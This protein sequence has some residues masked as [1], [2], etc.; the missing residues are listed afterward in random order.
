MVFQQRTVNTSV[1]KIRNRNR[2]G[3]CQQTNAAVGRI[4]QRLRIFCIGNLIHCNTAWPHGPHDHR[5]AHSLGAAGQHIHPVSPGK[6]F[7]KQFPP[8][9]HHTDFL[10]KRILPYQIPKQ[11]R[12]P[13]AGRPQNQ[14][15]TGDF[16][17]ICRNP[18]KIPGNTNANRGYASHPCHRTMLH[19][20]FSAQANPMSPGNGDV[21]SG[22]RRCGPGG[23][24]AGRID[25]IIDIFLGDCSLQPAAFL[26]KHQFRRCIDSQPQFLHSV[27]SL[28]IRIPSHPHRQN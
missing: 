24:P 19:H 1:P 10:R 18:R 9:I 21:A 11:R 7:R 12:F 27:L 28:F 14:Y 26:R 25:R 22:G 4:Q 15:G 17:G 13:P 3:C 2:V 6:A 20:H 8:F 16:G 23:I 5:D